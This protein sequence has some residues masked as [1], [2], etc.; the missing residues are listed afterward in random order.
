MNNSQY[1]TVIL[2]YFLASVVI[3]AVMILLFEF[4]GGN[5]FWGVFGLIF[6]SVVVARLFSVREHKST[7]LKYNN[8]FA[9]SG[10]MSMLWIL[11]YTRLF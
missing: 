1:F 7:I 6:L 4:V 3:A 10:G 2:K 9:I 8:H 5:I 11:I